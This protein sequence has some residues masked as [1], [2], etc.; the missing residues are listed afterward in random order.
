MIYYYFLVGGFLSKFYD[1][2]YRKMENGLP[3]APAEEMLTSDTNPLPIPLATPAISPLPMLLPVLT[4]LLMPLPKPLLTPLT[5]PLP[6]SPTTPLPIPVDAP[7]LTA[8]PIP[9]E[10]PLIRPESKAVLTVLPIE[11]R[12]APA[13]RALPE[14]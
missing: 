7:L 6:N 8:F 14:S 2:T 5:A 9:E 1:T 10:T 12:E 4:P 3:E 11:P 13:K